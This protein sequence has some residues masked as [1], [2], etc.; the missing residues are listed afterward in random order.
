MRGEG[1]ATGRASAT[2]GEKERRLL[3]AIFDSAVDCIIVINARGIIE[4]ANDAV[5]THFGYRPEEIIGQN[6]SVLMPESERP[7][8]DE[9]IAKYQRTGEAHII[10]IGRE[11]TARK[12]DGTHFPVH[13]AVS[14]MVVGSE[15]KYVGI[16][17]DISQAK[18]LEQSLRQAAEELRQA[19]EQ[20]EQASRAKD[21]FL[22]VL[23]HELRTPLTPVLATLSALEMEGELPREML[24]RLH[25]A[26]RNVELEARLIDDLLDLTRIERGK[27][28]LRTEVLD[29]HEVIEDIAS[30]CSE[31]VAAKSH[32][33]VLA[34]SAECR[35]IE[36]DPA[37]LRQILWNL[38]KNAVK[39]TPPGGIITIGTGN[40]PGDEKTPRVQVKVTD[41]GIGIP[42]D[43]LG[44]IFQAFEQGQA[45]TV[46]HFG[47]L[48]L[49]LA[50]TRALV[51]LHNG[52]VVAESD[53]PGKGSTFTLE[54]STVSGTARQHSTSEPPPNAGSRALR[55][56]LVEDHAD[57]LHVMRQL[58]TRMGHQVT[59]ACSVAEA[60]RRLAAEVPE[61]L[62]SDLGL[63]DGSGRDVMRYAC[64]VGVT[65]GIALSG[66]GM[67][68]DLRRSLEAGFVDHLTKPVDVRTLRETLS[69]LA[70]G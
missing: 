51:E 34:L 45:D 13:L 30:I 8:H 19:K 49:G 16:L 12:R 47:G 35:L 63:P 1:Y 3:R 2:A 57:T 58:L 24:D 54:L 21:R 44:R 40:L 28:H 9:Y 33:L 59:T 69:R 52:T 5:L 32:H 53:G 22:A 10:G 11:V 27:L 4:S 14:E 37:R 39:F 50:I 26:R 17:H 60:R 62:L 25:V 65:R 29:L 20:L 70:L 56:L 38:V 6:V 66:Y 18:Q 7:K 46:R 55:I 23:S 41:S 15:K 42:Q 68:E 43:S 31:D 64:E 36:G 61:L 67:E 48:G